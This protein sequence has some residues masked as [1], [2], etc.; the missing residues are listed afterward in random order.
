M[1]TMRNSVL[2]LATVFVLVMACLVAGAQDNQQMLNSA[3]AWLK[4]VQGGLSPE[5]KKDVPAL[6]SILRRYFLEPDSLRATEE[7]I[8]I[9]NALSKVEKS[10]TDRG[11]QA[12][13]NF[14]ND[15]NK[16]I[17][18]GIYRT[19]YSPP[20]EWLGGESYVDL[21]ATIALPMETEGD[22][23]RVVSG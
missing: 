1:K 14:C 22:E 16:R 19:Q 21:A 20:K 7:D 12:F 2:R 15:L 8:A 4:K 23:G 10:Y 11:G 9:E 5:V 6:E 17:Y 3:L 18:L 13:F